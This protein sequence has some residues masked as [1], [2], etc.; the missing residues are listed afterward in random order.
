MHFYRK[1]WPDVGAG[2][3]M[4]ISIAM[5]IF[6]TRSREKRSRA[7][8]LSTW[9]FVAL[10][11]HQCEE[12]RFPGYFPGQ[13]NAGVLKSETPDHY[14]LNTQIAMLINTALAY[15]VYVLPVLFPRKVWLGLAPVLMGF[16][17]VLIH[18]LVFPLRAKAR[19]G[20]GF[21]TALCLHLPIGIAYLRQI[22]REQPVKGSEWIKGVIA[23]LGFALGGIVV[24]ILFFRDKE[25]PY[26]FTKQQMGPY[27]HQ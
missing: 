4:G 11:L 6:L 21:V 20:P 26:R 13:F 17:Q 5:T 10:L 9:N 25:S 15:P 23:F 8:V 19:Y 2:F 3:V 22:R 16:A 27:A 12:Y 14:P 7:Q 1:H 24:P 18:G